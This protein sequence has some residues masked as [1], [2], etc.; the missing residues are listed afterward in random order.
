MAAAKY[1]N[2]RRSLK[3]KYVKLFTDSRSVLQ[4]LDSNDITSSIILN[5]I[6][7]LNTLGT[8]TKRLT[9][10]WI[11][12]HQG[13][14]GNEIADR[15]ANMGA[16]AKTEQI[17]IPVADS[18]VKSYINNCIYDTW[19]LNWKKDC[20]TNKHTKKF[21]PLPNARLSKRLLK[22]ERLDLKYL[23]EAITGHNY[24]RH[25]SN[26]IASLNST[27]C[28]LCNNDPETLLHLAN[29]CPTLAT[30]RLEILNDTKF[31]GKNSRWNPVKLLE[32]INI[33]CVKTLFS[34]N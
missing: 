17:Y 34:V 4:A 13:H 20:N 30:Y 1:M 6:E 23:L 11:K 21:F 27:R 10:N 26:K 24:L 3:P 19:G 25:F 5:T 33:P 29:S 16:L 2:K 28:R 32:F 9:L 8:K 15:L 22:F 14:E 7:T 31:E 18:L 12:A